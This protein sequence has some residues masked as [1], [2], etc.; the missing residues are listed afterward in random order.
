MSDYISTGFV[1]HLALT[2]S[3]LRSSLEFYTTL[4]GFQVAVEVSESRAILSNGKTLMALTTPPDP[5]QAIPDDRF[6]EKP[7]RSGSPQL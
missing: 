1:H 7:P 2:V 6:N 3:D 5:N 4:L